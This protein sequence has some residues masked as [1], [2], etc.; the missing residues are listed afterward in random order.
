M[1]SPP[2]LKQKFSYLVVDD[3][4]RLYDKGN[5]ES[6]RDKSPY[7]TDMGTTV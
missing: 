1:Y 6:L 3:N 7:H 4:G 5:G 2:I